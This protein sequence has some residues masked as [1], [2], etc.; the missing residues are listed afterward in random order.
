[1]LI[2]SRGNMSEDASPQGSK[3][4][5]ARTAFDFALCF[6]GLQFSYIIWGMMQELIMHNTYEPTPL[7]PSGKFPSATFCVF[8]NRFLAIII[9]AIACLYMHGTVSAAAPLLA[10]TPWYAYIALFLL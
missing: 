3:P 9:S 7:S 6:C 2:V 1:V 4:S 5:F 8:S 10:F